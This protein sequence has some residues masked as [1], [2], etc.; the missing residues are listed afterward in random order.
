MALPVS[1]FSGCVPSR[2]IKMDINAI[3]SFLAHL[4]PIILIIVGVILVFASKLAKFVGVVCVILGAFLL[5]LPYLLT[6]I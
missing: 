6:V 5:C 4:N 2:A 3:L 1:T